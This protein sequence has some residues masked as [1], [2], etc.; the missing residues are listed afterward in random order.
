MLLASDSGVKRSSA[1][2]A[3]KRAGRH[4]DVIVIAPRDVLKTSSRPVIRNRLLV[5][6]FVHE[7]PPGDSWHV[8]EQRI[9]ACISSVDVLIIAPAQKL[10]SLKTHKK[11][12]MQQLFPSPEEVEA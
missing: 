11:G 9:A 1:A 5:V 8:P 12:L 4:L 6:G 2:R 3:A 10:E 7:G